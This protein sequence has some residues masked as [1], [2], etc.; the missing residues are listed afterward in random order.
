MSK[1]QGRQISK[2]EKTNKQTLLAYEAELQTKPKKTHQNPG[3][4]LRK[5]NKD[6]GQNG[7]VSSFHIHDN[8]PLLI[9]KLYFI[10]LV[11][12]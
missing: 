11:C 1:S 3:C 8:F 2:S 9:V 5:D 12:S 4:P 6:S 10:W 7:P